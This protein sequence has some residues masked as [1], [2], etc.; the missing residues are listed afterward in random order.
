MDMVEVKI[1]LGENDR[2]NLPTKEIDGKSYVACEYNPD[3]SIHEEF[4]AAINKH[5][6]ERFSGT[7]DFII[8]DYLI[9]CLRSYE[10]ATQKSRAWNSRKV[11]SVRG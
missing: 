9:N 6:R 1:P 7:P 5:S 4:R 2:T 10:N 8:A 11:V 3:A